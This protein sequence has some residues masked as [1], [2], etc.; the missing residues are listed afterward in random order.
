MKFKKPVAINILGAYTLRESEHMVRAIKLHCEKLANILPEKWDWQEPVKRTFDKNCPEQMAHTVTGQSASVYWTR[1]GKPKAE[2]TF[3][4]GWNKA[5]SPQQAV[6]VHSNITLTTDLEQIEQGQLIGYLKAAS[7][8]NAADIAMIDSPTEAYKN[9]AGNNG[10]L[11]FYDKEGKIFNFQLVSR[12]LRHWLPDIFWG[13]VFGPAY[14]KLFGME[15]LLST[16][17]YTVEKLAEDMVYVQ[18]SAS[19]SDLHDNYAAVQ[20]TRERAKEHLGMEAFFDPAKAYDYR[21]AGIVGT[22]FRVPHL[23]VKP[24]P[25]LV[26]LPPPVWT[27]A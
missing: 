13:T 6:D 27:K 20:A 21:K 3:T 15:R 5:S 4:T 9:I 26:H 18:L 10:A 7:I 23:E 11:S 2:G 1:S 19:L 8:S 17:A 12:Q 24:E 16:P 25:N 22:V 14:V